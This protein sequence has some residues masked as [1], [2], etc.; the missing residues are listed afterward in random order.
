M[1]SLPL[2]PLSLRQLGP[3]ELGILWNDGHESKYQVRNLRLSCRCANCVDEWTREKILKDETVPLDIRP[4]KMETV[5]RY[6][7]QIDWSDGHNAGIFTFEQ[8][9]SHCECELCRVQKKNH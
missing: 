1:V 8:L 9:R 5:G 2:A 3:Q 4:K 7:L 6:A